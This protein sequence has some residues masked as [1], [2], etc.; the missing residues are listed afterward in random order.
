MWCNSLHLRSTPPFPYRA[1]IRKQPEFRAQF[2]A[3]CVS[4]GV[5]PLASN[6][7]IWNKLLGLGGETWVP[8]VPGF[9][10]SLNVQTVG[11]DNHPVHASLI[12]NY[13]MQIFTTS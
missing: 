9:R 1:D 8:W 12:T 4:I 7:G 10:K 6:K 11:P 5:D 2:Y 13:Q 3:M